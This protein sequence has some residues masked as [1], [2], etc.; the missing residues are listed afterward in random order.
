MRVIFQDRCWVV[1]I[2]FV[3]MV[4]FKFLAHFPVDHLAHPIIIIIMLFPSFTHQYY[5]MVF[6]WSNN[7]SLLNSRTFLGIRADLSCAVVWMN[8][9]LPLISNS[10]S[11]FSMLLWTDTRASTTVSITLTFIFL[12]CCFFFYSLARSK[13]LS[14][15]SHS[16]IF[17]LW[18]DGTITFPRRQIFFLS[19][20][21]KLNSRSAFRIR[22][23][24][25]ILYFITPFGVFTQALT[26]GL[27]LE[28]G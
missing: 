26:D 17:I 27:S 22:P 7:T 13:N 19:F 14:I 4:K 24:V 12:N 25:S 10:S 1:H 18:S 8:P 21:F 11:F 15:L 20:F 9:I 16:F 5:Q 3:G 2:P 28:S 23:S 6:H